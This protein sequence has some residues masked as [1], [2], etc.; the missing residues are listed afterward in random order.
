MK[1]TAPNDTPEQF[2][3][4]ITKLV[5]GFLES[6]QPLSAVAYL[7]YGWK[8]EI[9]KH[10]VQHDLL[11]LMREA[12]RAAGGDVAEFDRAYHDT[13]SNMRFAVQHVLGD[14][15]WQ[16]AKHAYQAMREEEMEPHRAYGIVIDGL[17]LSGRRRTTPSEPK[18]IAEA[19][20]AHA[21]EGAPFTKEEEERMR[22]QMNRL[23]HT[24]LMREAR[25]ARGRG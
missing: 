4:M 10:R 5:G 24:P 23:M 3:Q 14:R 17:A 21:L 13:N 15:Y 20:I 9:A 6:D 22:G 25:E 8:Q 7:A 2:K 19:R 16:Q 11:P 12:I 1:R 18:E